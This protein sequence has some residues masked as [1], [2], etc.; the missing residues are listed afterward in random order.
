MVVSK[1]VTPTERQE[2]HGFSCEGIDLVS[3][4]RPNWLRRSGI[5]F[6]NFD[7]PMATSCWMRRKA[8][9]RANT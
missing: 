3:H 9:W 6:D 4:S 7:L 1:I 8:T 5:R 2:D